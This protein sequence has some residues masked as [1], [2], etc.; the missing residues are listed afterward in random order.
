MGNSGGVADAN[1]V[2][3]Q[4]FLCR[5]RLEVLQGSQ[6]LAGM[7]RRR[8]KNAHGD[9]SDDKDFPLYVAVLGIAHRVGGE[10][11]FAVFTFAVAFPQNVKFGYC[12]FDRPWSPSRC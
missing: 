3:G 6:R 9:F 7:S 1:Q 8:P 10:R 2:R 4:V 5:V 11:A 12:S